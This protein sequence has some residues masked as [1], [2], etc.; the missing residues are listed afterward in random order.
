[1]HERLLS[2]IKAGQSKNPSDVMSQ[3]DVFGTAPGFR[4]K[5]GER[6][7][8]RI[9]CFV[10]A[11]WGFV[12]V[13]AIYYY[14]DMY[15]DRRFPNLVYGHYRSDEYLDADIVKEKF[16]FWWRARNTSTSRIIGIDDFFKSFALHGSIST[17][18]YDIDSADP[19]MTERTDWVDGKVLKFIPCKDT[20]WVKSLSK[21]FEENSPA[22]DFHNR[23]IFDSQFAIIK[24]QGICIDDREP[25]R[26]FY[27][28]GMM[29]GMHIELRKCGETHEVQTSYAPHQPTPTDPYAGQCD[30]AITP[31]K[32]EMELNV[33]ETRL[34]VLDYDYPLHKYTR[35]LTKIRPRTDELTST[36]IMLQASEFETN[37]GNLFKDW[38]LELGLQV[39][40]LSSTP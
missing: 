24:S 39:E 2:L 5:S 15:I 8:T 40:N 7:K 23:K 34:V 4:L 6:F 28:P 18:V 36:E 27:N 38:Q 22:A 16:H 17:Y 21:D 13:A 20:L 1:M 31:A 9:G 32:L 11:I 10:S 3:F 26:F 37:R 35:F 19:T 33:Y 25:L 30:H 12:I 29:R 14:I